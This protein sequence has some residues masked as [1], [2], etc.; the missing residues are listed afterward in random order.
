MFRERGRRASW[1]RADCGVIVT[2]DRGR[3]CGTAATK[4]TRLL[5]R[6]TE[7]TSMSLRSARS[8]PFAAT[9]AGPCTLSYDRSPIADN[10][11]CV[12]RCKMLGG[13]RLRS[14][15]DDRADPRGRDSSHEVQRIA[16][17]EDRRMLHGRPR[18]GSFGGTRNTRRQSRP[19]GARVA[20]RRCAGHLLP[21]RVPP[22]ASRRAGAPVQA[23]S[24]CPEGLAVD[25]AA[26]DVAEGYF[27][28]TISPFIG[29]RAPSS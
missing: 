1:C 25:V 2:I 26:P 15:Q 24:G 6:A 29:P 21:D 19:G 14:R 12:S 9:R 27:F 28:S 10:A 22:K 20:P 8:A 4:S 7:A 11:V 18:D 23:R 3:Q 17:P 5:S 13:G 16:G